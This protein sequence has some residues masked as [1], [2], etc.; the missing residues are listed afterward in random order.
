VRSEV[1]KCASAT[2][3]I[4][5]RLTV[6]IQNPGSLLMERPA[7]KTDRHWT[8]VPLTQTNLPK[9]PQAHLVLVESDME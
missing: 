8:G 7:E 4:V 5:F 2:V 6:V 1:D 9:S 3:R